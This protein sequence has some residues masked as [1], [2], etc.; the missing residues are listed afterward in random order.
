MDYVPQTMSEEELEQRLNDLLARAQALGTS[1]TET[2]EAITDTLD[3]AEKSIDQSI[4]I[5]DAELDALDQAEL[6]TEEALERLILKGAETLA[7]E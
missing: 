1:I 2:D 6:E 5:I 7:D 3:K 4:A